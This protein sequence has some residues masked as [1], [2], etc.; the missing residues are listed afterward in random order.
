MRVGV[1]MRAPNNHIDSASPEWDVSQPGAQLS[2]GYFRIARQ[3]PLQVAAHQKV[4]VACN[5]MR[6]LCCRRVEFAWINRAGHKDVCLAC[7]HAGIR[8]RSIA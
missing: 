5:C 8:S 3:I 6:R 7:P 1:N 4:N 2:A